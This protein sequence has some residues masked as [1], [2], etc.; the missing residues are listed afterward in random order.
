MIANLQR[1]SRNLLTTSGF[2]EPDHPTWGGPGWKVFLDE[3]ADVRRTI[4]YVENN[5]PERGLP[6][7]AWE[8]V[9]AYDDWPLHPGHSPNSPYVKRLRGRKSR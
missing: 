5:P 2:R 8:F 1:E 4:A 3:P 9:K 7:Q 6:R